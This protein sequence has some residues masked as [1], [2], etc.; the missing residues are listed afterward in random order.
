MKEIEK[1]RLFKPE[2]TDLGT[3][4]N[5]SICKHEQKKKKEEKEK[6]EDASFCDEVCISE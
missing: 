2:Q 6:G 1:A 4:E 5:S 3:T